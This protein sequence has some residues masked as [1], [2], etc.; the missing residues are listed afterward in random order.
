MSRMSSIED[1]EFQNAELE[2]NI[3][4]VFDEGKDLSDLDERN[5]ERWRSMI[6]ANEI[7]IR[8]NR[9]GDCDV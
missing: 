2:R 4:R 8:N 6:D 3:A 7:K 9:I 1:M 5:L